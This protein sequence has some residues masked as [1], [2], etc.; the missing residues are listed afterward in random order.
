MSAIPPITPEAWAMLAAVA[1]LFAGT[2]ALVVLRWRREEGG[3]FGC[4]RDA[5]CFTALWPGMNPPAFLRPGAPAP[6][7]WMEGAAA[8]LAGA[9][10]L[11][12]AHVWIGAGW[13]LAGA[14]ILVLAGFTLFL[15]FGAFTLVSAGYR[16][17]GFGVARPLGNPFTARDLREF[18]G[19]RWNRPFIELTARLVVRPL[20]RS[21]A[22]AGAGARR[23][24]AAVAFLWSGIVHEAAITLPIGEGCGGPTLYFAVQA[25]GWWIEDVLREGGRW[26]TLPGWVRRVWLWGLV[27]CPLPLLFPPAFVFRVLFPL[28]GLTP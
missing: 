2:K 11:A 8:C 28:A 17:A 21:D 10:L 3:A 14:G 25:A 1:V 7:W 20:L 6:R 22:L 5:V 18:W 9:A 23:R 13:G 4:V 26:N 27:L 12:L 16:A 15:H 24:A 19:N